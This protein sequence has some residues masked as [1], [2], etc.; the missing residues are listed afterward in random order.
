MQEA[1]RFPRTNFQPPPLLQ[2]KLGP[3]LGV[4]SGGQKDRSRPVLRAD[5]H[6]SFHQDTEYWARN[7]VGELSLEPLC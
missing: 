3:L 5:S 4:L 2:S 1:E 6:D 7:K